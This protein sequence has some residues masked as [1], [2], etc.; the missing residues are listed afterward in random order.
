LRILVA[1]VVP[2]AAS[3]TVA[4]KA[5]KTTVKFRGSAKN[6]RTSYQNEISSIKC[7]MQSLLSKRVF[8]FSEKTEFR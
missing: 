7:L 6:K 1:A 4:N 3:G 5:D 2:F 8:F